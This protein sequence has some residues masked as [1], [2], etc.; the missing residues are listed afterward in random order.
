MLLDG[1]H[2]VREA[3]ASRC[4]SRWRRSADAARRRSRSRRARWPSVSGAQ[5]V[6]VTAPVLAAISPVRAP[7]RRRRRSPRAPA[8]TLEQVLAQHAAARRDAA[9]RPGSRQRRRDRAR[10]GGLRRDRD[11]DRQRRHR[12]SVRLEGAA[13]RDGQHVSPAGRGR[14][15]LDD[16]VDDAARQRDSRRSPPTARGGTSLPACDLR[17]A[18]A[19]LLGGEGRRPA[20]TICSRQPTSDSP[21]RCDPPVESLNVAIAAALVLYEAARQRAGAPCGRRSDVAL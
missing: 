4:R 8:D 20:R 9:R 5:V 14:Q 13:R 21:F 11:R 17:G 3:L 18:C 7:V 2:L 6:V 10:R 1:E 16:A 19:I 15:S 12:G